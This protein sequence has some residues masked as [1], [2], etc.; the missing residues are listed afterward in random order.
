MAERTARGLTTLAFSHRRGRGRR[1][2]AGA[3]ESLRESAA[4]QVVDRDLH[5]E[6]DE[7]T[8]EDE[9]ECR[10]DESADE[11]DDEREDPGG[12]VVARERA[13]LD[14][15]EVEGRAEVALDGEVGERRRDEVAD[16][17]REDEET[18]PSTAASAPG[19]LLPPRP[20]VKMSAKYGMMRINEYAMLTTNSFSP[21]TSSSPQ[22]VKEGASV[23]PFAAA[24][25]TRRK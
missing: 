23:S 25:R 15:P 3:T 18:S 7:D 6:Q 17:E 16:D 1:T 2:P 9:A 21:S 10:A 8:D 5:V 19:P 14:R 12:R 4:E 11:T 13:V 20:M 22:S 24:R